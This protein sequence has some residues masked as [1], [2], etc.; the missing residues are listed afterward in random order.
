[1]PSWVGDACMATPTLRAL[2]AGF[3]DSEIVGIAS[4]LITDLLNGA[5]GEEQ[6][7]VDGFLLFSKSR[8]RTGRKVASRWRLPAHMKR[9]G[10]DVLILLTN[11]F[12]T[13]AAAWLGEVPLRVGY[14]RDGR[15][16]LLTDKLPVPRRADGSLQPVSAIDYYLGLADWMGCNLEPDTQRRR[17]QL[18]V[19]DSE[20]ELADSLWSRLGLRTHRP[21]IVINS[22]S[23]KQSSRVW[24]ALKVRELALRLVEDSDIQVLLHCGPAEKQTANE[25]AASANHERI[26]SMGAIQDLPIQLSK[27]VMARADVVVSTD[28]G[29]RHMA[30]ALDRPVVSLFGP[31]HP[32]WTTTYNRGE[33]VIFGQQDCEPCQDGECSNNDHQRLEIIEVDRVLEAVHKELDAARQ[34]SAA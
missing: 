13:A 11:S 28:S 9:Q 2:R 4:P 30:V 17:M 3:P 20:R 33:S 12:W 29:P 8:K 7:W 21:T 6:P 34:V 31:I 32:R 1:M 18:S 23:A 24:P 26:V 22:N 10:F 14:R 15:G 16:W 27:A 19:F 25:V 5:W